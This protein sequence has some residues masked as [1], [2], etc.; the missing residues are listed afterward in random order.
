[1]HGDRND[2]RPTPACT[3]SKRGERD[4]P[5]GRAS[6]ARRPSR[7]SRC[8]TRRIR[9]RRSSSRGSSRAR[10]TEGFRPRARRRSTGA[11]P[12]RET[13]VRADPDLA[14]L[15]R[16]LFEYP[17]VP[18]TWRQPDLAAPSDPTLTIR[19]KR[20]DVEVA[21]LTTITT[22]NAPQNATLEELRVESY[23]RST[24]PRRAPANI[25]PGT[26][27]SSNRRPHCTRSYFADFVTT[28]SAPERS[29]SAPGD[30]VRSVLAVITERDRCDAS[31]QSRPAR[32]SPD[33][34]TMSAFR[35]DAQ[36][37]TMRRL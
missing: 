22:F 28:E 18:E 27:I 35:G 19:L 37:G 9:P 10:V 4:L 20:G 21:F 30:V 14:A 11:E 7:G 25:S 16:S 31:F 12:E 24:T 17:S 5:G 34:A 23:F 3:D 1:M 13:L 36:G 26:G 6:T 2:L 32:R 15:L 33:E 8:S 29:I